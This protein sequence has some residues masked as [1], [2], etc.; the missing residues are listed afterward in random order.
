MSSKVAPVFTAAAAASSN[1]P[2]VVELRKENAALKKEIVELKKENA[3]LS[4]RKRKASDTTTISEPSKKAKTP[5]QRKKLFEKW[6]KALTRESAKT[7]LTNV[8]WGS[9]EL[10]DVKVKETTPW[11]VADFA[12]VFGG[13]G[14][15]I[16]PTKENKP[17]STITILEFDNME[18]IKDLFGDA[19]IHE[20]GYTASQ[21]RSRSFQKSYKCADLPA[22]IDSLQVHF[23]KS[24][25][26]LM[27]QFKMS[28]TWTVAI[29]KQ[30]ASL[31]TESGLLLGT[32]LWIRLAKC[33]GL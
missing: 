3:E 16:Q 10:F 2:L 30:G 9:T 11:T 15:K 6:T 1:D 26:S 14:N 17:T 8:Y 24:K 5:G 20:E 7:K 19:V 25:L 4:S 12:S 27:L 32:R 13:K 22:K 29:T 23:N 18:S 21:W 33:T 28:T 31:L